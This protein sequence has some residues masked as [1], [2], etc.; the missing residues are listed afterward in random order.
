MSLEPPLS[1]ELIGGDGSKV[2]DRDALLLRAVGIAEFHGA[3]GSR[4]D[5]GTSDGL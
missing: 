2:D 5:S 3:I 1:E 4:G